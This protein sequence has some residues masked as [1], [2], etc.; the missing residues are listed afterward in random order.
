MRFVFLLDDLH[1]GC[2]EQR[3]NDSSFYQPSQN[4]MYPY[5]CAQ[6][7][8]N[9][10][11][12]LAAVFNGTECHCANKS[13]I[14]LISNTPCA[15][16]PGN[17]K[18]F[19]I[20]NASCFIVEFAELYEKLTFMMFQSSIMP[21]NVSSISPTTLVT[22]PTVTALNLTRK[23]TYWVDFGDERGNTTLQDHVIHRYT[24]TGGFNVTLVA[25][26][27]NMTFLVSSR[28]IRV[29]ERLRVNGM[30]CSTRTPWHRKITACTFHEMRGSDATL[31]MTMKSNGQNVTLSVPGKFV[32]HLMHPSMRSPEGTKEICAAL[33]FSG[34][35]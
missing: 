23:A 14:S 6:A 26:Q 22:Q 4:T 12:P 29:V 13:T 25:S 8:A 24:T 18:V 3:N 11:F 1:L 17:A 2:Y 33:D 34:E 28:T 10:T 5:N 32:I 16:S 21:S 31:R 7:C 35:F 19:Q 27:D 20:Y 30:H 15:G 9:E